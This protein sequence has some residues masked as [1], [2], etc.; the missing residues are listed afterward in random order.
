M[1]SSAFVCLLAGLRKNYSTYFHK[2]GGK[3]AHG[4]WKKQFD[5][6]GNPDCVT[7]GLGLRVGW[8]E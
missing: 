1:F 6:D 2:I 3:E 5:S 4:P 7:S 8:R